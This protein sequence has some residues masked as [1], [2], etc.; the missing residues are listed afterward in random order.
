MTWVNVEVH[1]SGV[2]DQEDEEF[3]RFLLVNLVFEMV[4]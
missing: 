2:K 1:I 3:P 4:G